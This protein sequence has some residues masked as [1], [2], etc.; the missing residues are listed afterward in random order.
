MSNV[1]FTFE[2]EDQRN[3]F[4]K[5]IRNLGNVYAILPDEYHGKIDTD[6]ILSSIEIDIPTTRSYGLWISGKKMLEGPYE[7]INTLFN[8]EI[9]THSA[10]IELKEMRNGKWITIRSRRDGKSTIRSRQ[11]Q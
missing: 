6:K 3:D 9:K 2:N 11:N 10:N 1:L 4:L 7:K 8:Q 5:L